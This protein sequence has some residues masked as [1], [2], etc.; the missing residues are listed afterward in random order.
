MLEQ[1]FYSQQ[2]KKKRHLARR[3]MSFVKIL[4]WGYKIKFS[5]N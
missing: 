4:F 2:G 1:F 3:E 5:I